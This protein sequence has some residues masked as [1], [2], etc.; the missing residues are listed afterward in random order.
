[1]A[2]TNALASVAMCLLLTWLGIASART[3][4]RGP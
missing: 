1:M 4:V 3:L 2:L